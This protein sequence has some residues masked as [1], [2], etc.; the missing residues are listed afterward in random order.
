MLTEE[1]LLT[2][3]G[4]K[5]GPA[6]KI[7]AQVGTAGGGGPDNGGGSTE[8]L[9]S[10]RSPT[11]ACLSIGGQATGTRLLHGQLPR[12]FAA[13]ATNTAGPRAGACPHCGGTAIA[14][15]STLPLWGGTPPSWPSLTQ[16]RERDVSAPRACRPLPASVLS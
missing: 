11:Q 15:S 9:R 10:C 13:A 4:L 16:A 5:L 1:H 8:A 14:S 3:M 12:G 6:L 7:R 2:T